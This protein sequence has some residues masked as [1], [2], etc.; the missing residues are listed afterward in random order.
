MVLSIV[1][2]KVVIVARRSSRNRALTVQDTTDTADCR[3]RFLAEVEPMAIGRREP[4]HSRQVSREEI[5]IEWLHPVNS[6]SHPGGTL[7]P[8][9]RRSH[10][11]IHTTIHSR[12]AVPV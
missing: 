3:R 2:A 4:L 8:G 1:L 10:P 6:L 11:H 9:Q 12:A 7:I 5:V